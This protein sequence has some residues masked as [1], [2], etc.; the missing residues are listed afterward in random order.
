MFHP[1][2]EVLRYVHLLVNRV[3]GNKAVCPIHFCLVL[4]FSSICFN[5]RDP[6]TTLFLG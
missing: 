6:K 2:L 1:S 5:L 4:N 3:I